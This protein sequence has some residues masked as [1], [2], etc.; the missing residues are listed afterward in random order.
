M[1]IEIE[2][3]FPLNFLLGPRAGRG[4]RV[5]AGRGGILGRGGVPGCG[6]GGAVQAPKLRCAVRGRSVTPR[7]GWGEV[8]DAAGHMASLT[9]GPPPRH[10][11]P[12]SCARGTRAEGLGLVPSRHGVWALSR[13]RERHPHTR[14]L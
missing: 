10:L 2:T 1:K 12:P 5:R 7:E 9:P 11:S 13:L 4:P 8:H 3:Q 14:R 6:Q